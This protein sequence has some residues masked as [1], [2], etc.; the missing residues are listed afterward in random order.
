MNTTRRY[1]CESLSFQYR[2]IPIGLLESLPGHINDRAPAFRGRDELGVLSLVLH[3]MAVLMHRMGVQRHCLRVR[4]AGT[5]SRY[6]RCSL[7]QHL[8]HGCSHP[9]TRVM[10][11]MRRAKAES[12]HGRKYPLVTPKKL[13]VPYEFFSFSILRRKRKLKMYFG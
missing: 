3:L 10:H 9:S 11:M 2:Y 1:L 12:N 6:P 13:S 7:D 4:I 5:G 8:S